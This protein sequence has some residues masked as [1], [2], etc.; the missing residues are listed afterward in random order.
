MNRFGGDRFPQNG[1][2]DIF[3]QVDENG[4][5]STGCCNLESLV[6]SPWQLCNVLDH[7]VP[8]CT[9]PGDTDHV[10]FLEGIA[11]DQVGSDLSTKDDHGQTV[12]EGILHGR[13]DV[14]RSGSRSDKDDT[15]FSGYSSVSFSHVTCTLFVSGKD[16]VEVGRVVNSVKDG[17]DGSS[18]VTKDL[19][20]IVSEHHLLEDLSSRHSDESTQ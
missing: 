6:D 13:D 20:D 11:T 3:G 2:S 8:L 18:G 15:R 19:L 5:W 4:T 10:G 14:G 16:K 7:D 17:Q 12:R 1:S 9:T